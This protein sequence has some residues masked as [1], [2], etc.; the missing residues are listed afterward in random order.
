MMRRYLLAWAALIILLIATAA[1][2]RFDLGWG[3]VTLNL[4]IAIAKALLILFIFMGLKSAAALP[5]LAFG[6]AALWLAI[7]YGLILVDYVTR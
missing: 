6:A 5:R 1:S 4:A 3:N 2:S 7:M